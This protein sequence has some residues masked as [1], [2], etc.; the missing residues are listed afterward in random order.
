MTSGLAAP[1][2]KDGLLVEVVAAVHN[3]AGVTGEAR[4]TGVLRM[5]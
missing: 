3:E 5:H 1:E 4:G 2:E